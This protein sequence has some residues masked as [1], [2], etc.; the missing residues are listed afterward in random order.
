LVVNKG[1]FIN[2]CKKALKLVQNAIQETQ[3]PKVPEEE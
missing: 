2:G 1:L 3:Y